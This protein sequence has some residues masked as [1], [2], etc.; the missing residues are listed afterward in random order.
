MIKRIIIIWI[1]FTFSLIWTLNA[2][3]LVQREQAIF[4]NNVELYK[5]GEFKNAENNFALII[6]KLPNSVF[7]TANYL[8]LAKTQYKLRDYT[9]TIN[10]SQ[11]FLELFPKSE[12]CDDILY[13][14]GN[15]YYRLNR[16][17]TAVK[18]WINAIENSQNYKLYNKVGDII[19]ST[20]MYKLDN[21]EISRIEREISSEDGQLLIQIALAEKELNNSSYLAASD[22]IDKALKN[23]PN[24]RFRDR[25]EDLMSR[26]KKKTANVMRIALLL[27]LT[28]V[29]Q[30][31]GNEIK[32][33][34][35]FALSEYN[36]QKDK[37]VELLIKDYGQEITKAIQ[38]IKEIARD[39]SI[40]AVLGPVEN[41]IAAA[42][43]ALSDYEQLPIICPT[44]TDNNLTELSDYF[45]QLN[46]I[47]D[48]Q[49][50]YLARYALDSLKLER[51]VTFSPIENHFIKLVDRFVETVESAGAKIITQE[52]YYP[53]DQDF[54]KQFMRIK[55]IGL[56][57]AF[58]DSVLQ[59]DS[60]LSSAEIDTLYKEYHV[61]EQERLEETKTKIDS[62]DI[63]VYTIDG[64]FIP[65]FREDMQFIGPQIAYSNIQAQYIGN[66]DW[67]D[68]EQLKKQKNY[69]DGIIFG[70]DGFINEESW[71]Y[72]NLRNDYR[73]KINKTPTLFNILGVD[74]I[75]FMLKGLE[76]NTTSRNRYIQNLKG[77]EY[78]NGI[79]RK[80]EM[81]NRRHNLKLQ[82]LKYQFGQ[83]IPLN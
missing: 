52:W 58:S 34:V 45:L 63:P 72:K 57:Y 41:D 13:V 25:A 77:I 30:D 81:D 9:A 60:T 37:N 64:I 29:N 7:L 47:I 16:F 22:R 1:V 21:F 44:A 12:Y 39:K 11:K 82:L 24:S 79:Y 55:R 2:Q 43:A 56:K 71:D 20:I 31:I 36:R 3:N 40:I 67:Y 6:T 73:S 17:E 14:Q 70:T 50:D 66:V 49:A 8:M 18:S 15:C 53:G 33:G 38:S 28:G 59:V 10:L 69:I 48:I 83:I 4:Q 62:A 42:C 75:R 78:Y 32:E 74:V 5:R 68:I 23:F 26:G 46:P 19:F 35:E 27:P 54:N 80:I 76:T 65:I 61:M 51:F